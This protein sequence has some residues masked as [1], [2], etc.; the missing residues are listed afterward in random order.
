MYNFLSARI[1]ARVAGGIDVPRKGG[2]GGGP[3]RQ[4]TTALARGS[5][6]LSRL[7][8]LTNKFEL[9]TYL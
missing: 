2:G 8:E 6:Q 4:N 3:A 7:P 1:I 5:R 9:T